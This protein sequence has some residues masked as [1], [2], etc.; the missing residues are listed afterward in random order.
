ME[1]EARAVASCTNRLSE[2]HTYSV[3]HPSSRRSSVPA[4][5]RR[6]WRS[7]RKSK[8]STTQGTTMKGALLQVAG[9]L[10]SWSGP[11]IGSHV[12]PPPECLPAA[13][14]PTPVVAGG[15]PQAEKGGHTKQSTAHTQSMGW[16]SFKLK[17][18][19]IWSVSCLLEVQ[20]SEIRLPVG[21][22]R[23]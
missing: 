16:E 21:A 10:T 15:N 7:T 11:R 6:F 20:V 12:A 19:Q 18:V 4:V 23:K 1:N 17:S 14:F 2:S 22:R 3:H 9:R 13:T 8:R 5:I